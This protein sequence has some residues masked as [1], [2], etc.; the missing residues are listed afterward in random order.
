L[1]TPTNELDYADNSLLAIGS[2][3]PVHR[4]GSRYV[5]GR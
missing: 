1:T 4:H 2:P 3:F 5:R